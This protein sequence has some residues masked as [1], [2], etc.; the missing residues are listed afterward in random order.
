[1]GGRRTQ[2]GVYRVTYIGDEST[3]PVKAL[4]VGKDFELRAELETFHVDG[5]D[6]KAVLAK[7]WPQLDHEDR[8]IRF[9]ARAAIERLPV[10]AWKERPRAKPARTRSSKLSSP[11]RG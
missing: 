8:H 9:A 5:A 3:T 11:W 1:M 6:P 4:P 10:D 7:T 2:S